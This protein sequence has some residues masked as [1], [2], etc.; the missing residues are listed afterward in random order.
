MSFNDTRT[1]V[2]IVFFYHHEAKYDVVLIFC[3]TSIESI[4]KTQ[5]IAARL[6]K[7]CPERFVFDLLFQIEDLRG[8]ECAVAKVFYRFQSSTA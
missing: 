6:E 1:E 3:K 8:V 2:G 5:D 4:P 7:V